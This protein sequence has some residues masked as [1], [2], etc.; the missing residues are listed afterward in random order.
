MKSS[1]LDWQSRLQPC[2]E[3]E[4]DLL[5]LMQQLGSDEIVILLDAWT[6]ATHRKMYKGFGGLEASCIWSSCSVTVHRAVLQQLELG[7]D[8]AWHRFRDRS[9]NSIVCRD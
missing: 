4:C 8:D 1:F 3:I 7:I 5:F 2:C 6:T 9:N